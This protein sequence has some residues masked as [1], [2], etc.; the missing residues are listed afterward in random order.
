VGNA[1]FKFDD[2]GFKVCIC[3]GTLYFWMV[4]KLSGLQRGLSC[5][6]QG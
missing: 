6:T 2:A 3:H 1:G 4:A 5:L